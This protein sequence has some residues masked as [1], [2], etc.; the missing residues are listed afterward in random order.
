MKVIVVK[1]E[2]MYENIPYFEI[3]GCCIKR[4]KISADSDNIVFDAE[5]TLALRITYRINI[6]HTFLF[7]FLLKGV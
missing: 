6:C 4:K 7:G 3:M 5:I 1:K 2:I